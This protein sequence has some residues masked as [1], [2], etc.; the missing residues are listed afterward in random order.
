VD[1]LDHKQ[2]IKDRVAVE[3]EE[4]VDRLEMGEKVEK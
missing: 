2:V 1:R 3:K 4:L